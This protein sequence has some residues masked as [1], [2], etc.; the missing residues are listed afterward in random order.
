MLVAHTFPCLVD[1]WITKGARH[2]ESAKTGRLSD[3]S[4]NALRR[5][6]RVGEHEFKVAL[7]RFSPTFRRS[8]WSLH[9]KVL[10]ARS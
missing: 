9:R 6:H 2:G 4:F 10:Q 5:L 1:F 7:E 3:P 8:A